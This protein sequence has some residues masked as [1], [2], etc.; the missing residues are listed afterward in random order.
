M[1]KPGLAIVQE[2]G[3]NCEGLV[4]PYKYTFQPEPSMG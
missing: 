1:K 3:L 2:S 4:N